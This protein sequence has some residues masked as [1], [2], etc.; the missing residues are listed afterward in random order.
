LPELAQLAAVSALPL[1]IDESGQTYQD[2]LSASQLGIADALNLK[3]S[4]VGGLT[5]AARI[6]DLAEAVGMGILVDEPQGADLATAAMAQLAA[7]IDPRRFLGVSYFMGHHMTLSY[8]K[9][10]ATTGPG[11]SDGS[12]VLTDAPGLGVTVDEEIFGEP[13]YVLTAADL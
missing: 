6:R 2:V 10:G 1:M 5:K 12:V 8:Q 11:F 9:E 4:R 13:I 7:S 3:I